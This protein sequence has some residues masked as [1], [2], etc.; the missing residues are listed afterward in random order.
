MR[1]LCARVLTPL[2]LLGVPFISA[3]GQSLPEVETGPSVTI[4]APTPAASPSP[5][6]AATAAPIFF[7][8]EAQGIGDPN[9]F[10]QDGRYHVF[11]LQNEGRH[12]WRV[13][14][15][16][17][18][19]AWSAPVEAVPVGPAGAPDYWTGSGSVVADPA[20]GYRIFYTG[21]LP[22]GNPKEIVMAS[23]APGLAGPWT[24][25]TTPR[26]SGLPDYDRWDF[27]DPFVFW[28]DE[29]KAW[30]MLL[31]TRK[32]GQ[33]AIGL[34][35][36]P[37]LDRWTAAPPLYAEPSP[38][39]LEVPDLFREGP[40]WFLL[41]SDQRDASRQTRYLRAA[42][43]AGPYAYGAFDALD[44][45]GFYAGK[46]AG[47]GPNRLLFGWIAHRRDKRDDAELEWGGDLVAHA[48]RRTVD[49]ALAVD[50]ADPVARQFNVLAGRLSTAA[51]AADPIGKGTRITA[52]LAVRPGGRF[53]IRFTKSGAIAAL[54]EIDPAAQQARFVVGS[55]TADAPRVAFPASADGRYRIDLLLDPRQGFGVLYINRFRALS[56]RYYGVSGTVPAFYSDGGF[57]ALDGEVRT[58]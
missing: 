10:H 3:C 42:T 39:N 21:H 48:I 2:T 26:F 31:T 45:R 53:G 54:A 22:D 4:P 38:L 43:S 35:T 15:S 34:Y 8:L 23:H 29:A 1:I 46:T 47:A 51:P 52:G 44:G 19:T 58:K 27:R 9:P 57:V 5:D 33:A 41:Y 24:K 28:N 12:P 36:S 20:G 7:G 11:Y 40:D 32:S 16:A 18:L 25:L 37:D 49:G 30:W 6:P 17:D 14:S 13:S 55:R 50:I 56:F